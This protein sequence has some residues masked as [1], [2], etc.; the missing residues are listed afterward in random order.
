MR[1]ENLVSKPIISHTVSIRKN[2]AAREFTQT[3][4][5]IEVKRKNKFTLNMVS[6]CSNVITTFQAVTYSDKILDLKSLIQEM[7][8]LINEATINDCSEVKRDSGLEIKEVS[9][10]PFEYPEIELSGGSL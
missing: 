6:Y 7:I 4:K 9:S 1:K 8:E 3:V 10:M 5:K 2:K